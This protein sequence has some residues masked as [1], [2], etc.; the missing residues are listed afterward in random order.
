MRLGGVWTSCQPIGLPHRPGGKVA[1]S[2]IAVRLA[3]GCA[4]GRFDGEAHTRRIRLRMHRATRQPVARAPTREDLAGRNKAGHH[5]IFTATA[6]SQ[7]MQGHSRNAS[8]CRPKN[9]A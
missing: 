3:L 7:T 6:R 5:D 8:H 4:W 1:S 9:V 2:E